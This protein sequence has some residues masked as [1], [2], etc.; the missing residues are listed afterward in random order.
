MPKQ[1]PLEIEINESS[2]VKESSTELAI[3]APKKYQVILYNDDYTPMA[4]VVLV[5][6]KF[7]HLSE[8]VAVQLMM[9]VHQKGRAVCGIF[10]HDIAETIVGLVTGYSRLNEYPLLCAMVAV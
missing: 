3:Q 7:F 5:I 6:Q 2:V 1:M 10:T 4:F 8:E 9:Q